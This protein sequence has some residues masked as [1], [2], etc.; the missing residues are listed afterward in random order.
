MILILKLVD[1]AFSSMLTKAKYEWG[2]C[3]LKYTSP[4]S[5]QNGATEGS[6]QNGSHGRRSFTYAT[7][8]NRARL[9]TTAGMVHLA[10]K[11]AEFPN[12]ESSSLIGLDL[13]QEVKVRK[14]A[15]C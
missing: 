13:I 6:Q 15:I 11:V 12:L 10:P 1:T 14:R 5:L 3:F 7:N 2:C 4:L 8:M 9:H